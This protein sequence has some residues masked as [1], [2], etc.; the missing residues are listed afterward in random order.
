[1]VPTSRTPTMRE[2]LASIPGFNM[3]PKKRTNKKLSTA[4]QLEQTK[5][6]CIDLETPDSTLVNTNLRHL[7]N[8]ATFAALPLLYQNKLV[9]LL[10]SVDRHIVNSA[11]PNA[12]EINN[13]GLNNEFFARA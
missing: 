6:G 9:Q 1:M 2:V 11:D 4:A 7:L 5:E 3:K 13:S 8:K 10:P 12:V